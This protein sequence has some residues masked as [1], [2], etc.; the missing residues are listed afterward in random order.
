MG[1]TAAAGKPQNN[2][3]GAGGAGMSG[4]PCPDKAGPLMKAI[5]LPNGGVMCI[6][7]TEVTQQQYEHFLN[8]VGPAE[9]KSQPPHCQWNKSFEPDLGCFVGDDKVCVPGAGKDCSNHPI[10]CVD[11]CDAEAYCAWAGKRLCGATDGGH[12]LEE[13]LN[14]AR[15]NQWLNACASG[16][17]SFLPTNDF[18]YGN[19]FALVCN[20][21][22]NAG[23]ASSGLTDPVASHSS[24]QAAGDYGGVYDLIGNASEMIDS[25]G[26]YEGQDDCCELRGGS[27]LDNKDVARCVPERYCILRSMIYHNVGFRCCGP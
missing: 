3:G 10:V 2:P 20:E 12:L 26:S 5:P 22:D 13:D 27:F 14:N 16:V 23:G 8:S 21:A 9:T 7:T 19:E 24:C 1:G 17:T 11:H 6:D 4:A 18:V 15:K 25:C